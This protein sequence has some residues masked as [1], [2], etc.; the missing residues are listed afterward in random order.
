[1]R[2][3]GRRRDARGCAGRCAPCGRHGRAAGGCA[4]RGELG[5][6]AGREEET[7]A[8]TQPVGSAAGAGNARPRQRG[9]RRGARS[10]RHFEAGVVPAARRWLCGASGGHCCRNRLRHRSGRRAERVRT[11]GPPGSPSWR[12]RGSRP[13]PA[14]PPPPPAPPPQRPGRPPPRPG[15]AARCPLPSAPAGG[16]RPADSSPPTAAGKPTVIGLPP[17]RHRA[18]RTPTGWPSTRRA[19]G[20]EAPLATPPGPP[21]RCRPRRPRDRQALLWLGKLP[22]SQAA[23]DQSERG[24]TVSYLRVPPPRGIGRAPPSVQPRPEPIGCWGE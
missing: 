16:A 1:M 7:G 11:R 3:S 18:H 24:I 23:R 22:A 12:G 20:S 8:G 17:V 6:P 2:C 9:R 13:P 4:A 10:R 19:S 21:S 5:G 14:E 15:A